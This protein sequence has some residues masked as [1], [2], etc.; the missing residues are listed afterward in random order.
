MD[1]FE[2][3]IEILNRMNDE[4]DSHEEA[5]FYH[6]FS[7]MRL[8]YSGSSFDPYNLFCYILEENLPME[9]Y[10]LQ[11]LM[12]VYAFHAVDEAFLDVLE[13]T[14]ELDCSEYTQKSQELIKDYV[15]DGFITAYRGEVSI[16]ENSNLPYQKSV[17]YSLDY[18]EAKHFATRFNGKAN[19]TRSIVYTFKVPIDDV[20]AYI[21]RED[22]VICRPISRGGKMEVIKEENFVY[23]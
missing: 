20:I 13:E 14:M 12:D 15:Q 18:D 2:K 7:K 3:D 9:S 10:Y 5:D 23:L 22:E 1:K 19:I 16:G 17:S 11:A 8:K 6:T 4:F 21:D